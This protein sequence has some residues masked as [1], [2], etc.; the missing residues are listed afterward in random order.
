MFPVRGEHRYTFRENS[1]IGMRFFFSIRRA[2]SLQCAALLCCGA[3]AWPSLSQ[4]LNSVDLAA[5]VRTGQFQAAVTAADKLL[6]HAPTDAYT[7]LYRGLAENGLGRQSEA[8]KDVDHALALQ[9]T[10]LTAAEAGAQIAYRSHD[11]QA[12]AFLQKVVTLD[13]AN[14]TAHAMLGVI[15]LE[16][17]DCAA[18]LAD[19]AKAGTVSDPSIALR[20]GMCNAQADA[21]AGNLRGAEQTLAALHAA[22]PSEA[23]VTQ[24]LAEVQMQANEPAKTVALLSPMA[25]G[26]SAAMLNLLASAYSR[27]GNLTAAVE[28]YRRAISAAPVQQDSYLDLATLSM[29]HQS[30]E[31]ALSVLDSGLKL[32]PDAVRLLV[33]RGTVY[34]QIGKNDLAQNDFEQADRLQPNSSY[35]AVGLGVLLREDGNLDEAQAVLEKKLQ[36]APG[37]ALISFMLADVLVRKGATPGDAS[38]T[39]AVSLLHTALVEQPELAPAHALLGKLLLKDAHPEQ[40]IAELESAIRLQPTDRTALNQL[41]AA[42]RRIGRTS[43]AARVSTMLEQSVAAERAQEN[44]KNR[45]HLSLSDGSAAA[46]GSSTDKPA[47]APP[48]P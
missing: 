21:N 17:E 3:V 8:L 33:M 31:V 16:R 32:K 6:Q 24:A 1:G 39:R 45:I 23:S 34:A 2:R 15:A 40:A 18:A 43:D 22:H 37:N 48:R 13:P 44:E 35:G 20:L 19:F 14:P 41:V 29:E 30:P 10:L 42:Y 7:W 27:A 47:D 25:G 36:R 12:P 11:P 38:F 26:L 9:P 4:T 5:L 28:T 46:Q